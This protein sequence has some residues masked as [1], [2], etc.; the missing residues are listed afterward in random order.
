MHMAEGEA[1]DATALKCRLPRRPYA[2]A[3]FT[4]PLLDPTEELALVIT[5][6]HMHD[7]IPQHSTRQLPSSLRTYLQYLSISSSRQSQRRRRKLHSTGPRT[8]VPM[9]LTARAKAMESNLRQSRT[10]PERL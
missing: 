7:R 5:T 6:P 4:T 2:I 3:F 10:M 1:R 8:H 9:F